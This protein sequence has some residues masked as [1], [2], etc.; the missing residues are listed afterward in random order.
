MGLRATVSLGQPS[1]IGALA[2]L[3]LVAA[4][5][6]AQTRIPIDLGPDA[7]TP[8]APPPVVDILVD[9]PDPDR[10]TPAQALECED[11]VEASAISGEIV[12]CRKIVDNSDRLSGSYADWLNDYAERTANIGAPSAPDDDG[13]GLP[14]GMAALVTINGCFLPPCPTPPAVLIDVEALPAPPI[15]SDAYWRAKGLAA[16]GHEGE[17]TPEARRMLEAELGLP[18]KP[19]FGDE[20][21]K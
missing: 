20:A 14:P 17:L 21:E 1:F 4:P 6:T 5:L 8:S 11:E 3:S 18:P 9:P 13:T 19:D 16:R 15:G 2:A 10:P 7:A 12:V